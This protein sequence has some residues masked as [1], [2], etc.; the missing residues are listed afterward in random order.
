MRTELTKKFAGIKDLKK[1]DI[2]IPK[3]C[4]QG[5]GQNQYGTTHKFK[6][7][8]GDTIETGNWAALASGLAE[9]AVGTVLEIEYDGK[10]DTRDGKRSYHTFKIYG[11]DTP[12][13][14]P[15]TSQSPTL[16]T[17]PPEVE[18]DE[19]DIDEALT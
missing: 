19:I 9:V 17:T 13:T 10:V 4:Y 2:L 11:F 16:L 3:A 18:S 1:G 15:T 6:T 5:R 14:P 8:T 12:P 7:E